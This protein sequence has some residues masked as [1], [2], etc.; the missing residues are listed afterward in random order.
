MGTSSTE[1]RPV[2]PGKWNT[3]IRDWAAAN[4]WRKESLEV[5]SDRHGRPTF[6]IYR[7]TAETAKQP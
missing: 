3:S 4:G 7:F 2:Y 1:T 5:V 6:E